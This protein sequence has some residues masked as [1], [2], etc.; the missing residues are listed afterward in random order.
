MPY[1]RFGMTATKATNLTGS[2]LTD[3]ALTAAEDEIRELLG[4]APD[5]SLYTTEVDDRGDPADRRIWAYGRAVAWQAAYRD[6]T[7]ADPVE[8]AARISS[9]SIG[10]GDYTVS[11]A[12]DGHLVGGIFPDRVRRL[13]ISGGW[14]ARSRTGRTRP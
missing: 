1:D 4:T 2:T 14:L 11:Y 8:A 12:G 7:P 10:G 3:D 6:G 5:P 13:L 9:E